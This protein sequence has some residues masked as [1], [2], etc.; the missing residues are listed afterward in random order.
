MKVTR[1]E[2]TWYQAPFAH[3]IENSSFRY[4]ASNKVV[5]RVHTDDG[6]A[7]TGWTNGTG[8]AMAIAQ[9]MGERILGRDPLAR[10]R[11]LAV[12]ADDKVYGRGG[13]A[14]KA[15]S[16]IDIALWDLAGLASGLSLHRML[17]GRHERTDAYVA[18][19]YYSSGKDLEALADEAL[20]ETS[21]GAR[22]FKMK[23][24]RLGVSEDLERVAAVRE[25]VGPG[26]RLLVDANGGYDRISAREMGRGLADLGVFWFEEPIDS[27]DVEGQAELRRAVAVPIAS[28]ES[29]H[30]R[31]EMRRAIR[32]GAMDFVNADAQCVD[33]VTGWLE[34]ASMATAG[35][36]AVAPH[37]DQELHVHLAAAAPSGALVEFYQGVNALRESMFQEKLELQDDGT[38]IPPDRPGIGFALDEER[39][40]AFRQGRLVAEA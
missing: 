32:A 38:V 23:V 33:G 30:S 27:R 18:G 25:A 1:V 36:L 39:L 5:V 11:T 8:L 19:G 4:R 13:L 37:G 14:A 24:G 12:L 3:P 15:R 20:R 29:E 40:A 10:D 16:A 22:A 2:A 31:H 6:L 28:G 17:G 9:D 21:S 7:G 34:A 35:G 26:V